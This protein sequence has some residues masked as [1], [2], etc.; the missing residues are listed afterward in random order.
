MSDMDDKLRDLLRQKAGDLPPHLDVP[1]ALAGRIRRRVALNA[2]GVG[3]MV[4]ALAVG[5]FAGVRAL[6][7]PRSTGFAGT[8]TSSVPPTPSSDSCTSGQLRAIG[9]VKVGEGGSRVGTIDLTN[10]S[11]KTCTLEGTPE[12]TLLDENLHPITSGVTFGSSPAR[13]E[14]IGSGEPVG[15]PV[16]TLAPGDSASV[17]IAW[18]NW[19]PDG[20]AAPLW[21]VGIPDSGTVD[22][23]NGMDAVTPPPCDAQDQPPA[24][25]VGPF[26]PGA[27]APTPAA[28]VS[29]T[30][31]ASAVDTC[32]SGQLRA[33]GS[34]QGA[35][36]SR[37]GAITLTNFSDKTCTL[38]GTPEIQL[39]D[40]NLQPITTDVTFGSSPAGWEA[41]GSPEP[42][43]W[44]VVTLAPG[45]SASVRIDWS[46]WCPDGRAAP[47]WR[48]GIPGSGMVDVINGMDS[49]TPPPC[50]GP[51][52]P[53]MIGVGPF[54]PGTGS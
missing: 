31:V 34:L 14:T 1:P 24:I 6:G 39:L 38:E 25:A 18:S 54:E 3:I 30:L 43:G 21:R 40:G 15:W 9:S 32:N 35:A 4:V 52:Q 44:P 42:A 12:I 36:G 47:L 37:V 20:A 23:I 8:P 7:G 5:A 17:R 11:D 29:P 49:E 33:N 48:V 19:C 45:D 27:V 28:S 53:S 46:N 50:N 16:V 51:G 26:E 10:F 41:N 22:V 2:V 13:W